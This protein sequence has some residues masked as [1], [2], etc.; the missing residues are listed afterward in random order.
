MTTQPRNSKGQ[1]MPQTMQTWNDG[2]ANL[3][4]KIDNLAAQQN[5][6]AVDLQALKSSMM[7]RLEIMDSLDKRVPL[8]V[9]A[10]DKNAIYARITDLENKPKSIRDWI[11]PIISIGTGCLS[12]ILAAGGVIVSAV[13]YF[14][15][16]P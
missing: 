2:W 1:F 12:L 10:V 5:Q 6:I 13:V 7:T 14:Q 4:L 15:A 11:V 3:S 16:H 9:Y 8:D